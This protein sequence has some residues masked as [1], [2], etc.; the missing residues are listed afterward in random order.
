MLSKFSFEFKFS[1]CAQIGGYYNVLY[2]KETTTLFFFCLRSLFCVVFIF[3][4]CLS[5]LC[6]LKVFESVLTSA[7]LYTSWKK[8]SSFKG[9]NFKFWFLL[10][11]FLLLT[12]YNWKNSK[13]ILLTK[14]KIEFQPFLTRWLRSLKIKFKYEQ[15]KNNFKF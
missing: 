10:K 14:N 15:L 3:G 4:Y 2:L 9:A 12:D 6:V 1:R 13:N 11:H 7:D 8:V 5:F